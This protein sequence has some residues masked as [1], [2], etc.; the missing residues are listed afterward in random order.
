M[1]RCL[2][3]PLF[4]AVLFITGCS[5]FGLDMQ[6]N[7]DYKHTYYSTQLNQNALEFMK[8]RPDL[9]SGMLD[10]IK[11]VEDIEPGIWDLYTSK[12]NTYL[13]LTNTAL[14]D[15]EQTYAYFRMNS[16]LIPDPEDTI[17]TP[18]AQIWGNATLWSQYDKER[19][20]EF[21]KYHIIKGRWGYE[22]LGASMEWRDTY[23][24]GD[25]AKIYLNVSNDRYGYLYVNNYV[26][27]PSIYPWE[28]SQTSRTW[29]GIQPRTPDLQATNGVVHVMDRWV[30]PP[31]RQILGL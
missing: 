9:F 13:L 28:N 17:N 8:S 20:R 30:F 26:G 25:T 4:L 7:Y 15:L 21:L 6:E 29:T 11:Y 22:E 12:N 10:A 31:V 27:V 14:T 1:K 2:N 18:P 5:I 3:I 24:S 19:I 16:I 23:A